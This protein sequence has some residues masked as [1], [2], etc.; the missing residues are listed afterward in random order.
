[1]TY[2][3]YTQ[4]IGHLQVDRHFWGESGGTPLPTE[5]ESSSLGFP[6]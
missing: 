1:M 2:P 4:V 5:V 6:H 3:G